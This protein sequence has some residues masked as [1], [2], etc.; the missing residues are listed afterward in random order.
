MASDALYDT[1]AIRNYSQPTDEQVDMAHG[2][3]AGQAHVHVTPPLLLLGVWGAL[4]FLTVVTV[5]VTFFE[6]GDFNVWVAL[7]VAVLKAGLVA[8][9]F[10]HLRWDSPFNGA[11]LIISLF[12]VAIFIGVSVLDSSQYQK[13]EIA[14]STHVIP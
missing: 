9:Y 3:G 6:L 11:V 7:A 5:G 2:H 1:P 12:F 14:P 4:L 13:N 10:M 8:M